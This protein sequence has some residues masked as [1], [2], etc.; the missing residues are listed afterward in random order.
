M[1][2][3]EVKR[4]QPSE[5]FPEEGE[6]LEPEESNV[7]NIEDNDITENENIHNNSDLAEPSLVDVLEV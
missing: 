6:V 5:L 4:I 2:K 3:S 1:L 7:E